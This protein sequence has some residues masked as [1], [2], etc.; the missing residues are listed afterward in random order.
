[1]AEAGSWQ[2]PATAGCRANERAEAYDVQVI[3]LL[4]EQYP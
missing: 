2:A 3:I 1:M 4:N